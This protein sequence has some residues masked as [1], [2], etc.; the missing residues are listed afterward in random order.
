M[1]SKSKAQ[2]ALMGMALA[3]RRGELARSKVDKNVLDIVDGDMSD[4][5]LEHFASTK[6][7]SLPDHIKESMEL[8]EIPFKVTYIDQDGCEYTDTVLAPYYSAVF[9]TWG[10]DH[11]DW[12]LIKIGL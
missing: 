7:K 11:P 6:H 12:K 2:Q 3:I 9:D 8:G 5:D 4:S 1:P 10:Q